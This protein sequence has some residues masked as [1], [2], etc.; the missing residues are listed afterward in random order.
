M[1]APRPLNTYT[2]ARACVRRVL[3]K[4]LLD[5]PNISLCCGAIGAWKAGAEINEDTAGVN[6]TTR[7][8]VRNNQVDTIGR[9]QSDRQGVGTCRS[10]GCLGID[11]MMLL[12]DIEIVVHTCDDAME[13]AEVVAAMVGSKICE[14]Q[15]HFPFHRIQYVGS[16]SDYERDSVCDYFSLIETYEITLNYNY[17]DAKIVV[18]KC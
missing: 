4:A 14:N 1:A 2:S 13:F 9:P 15:C 8:F 17:C 6:V 7:R 5:C 18:P 11:E 16:D 10:G 3:C 12:V